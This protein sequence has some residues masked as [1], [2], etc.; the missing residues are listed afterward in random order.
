MKSRYL[1]MLA[2]TA[3]TP[4]DSGDWI[5]EIKW[6]G[7]R[8]IAYVGDS[9][10][11]K[12]RNDRELSG[13]FPELN[14]L[15]SLAPG[16]VLD[17]EIIAMTGGKPDIQALLPRLQVKGGGSRSPGEAPVT[18]IIFDILEK[19][20]K[21]LT[22]LPLSERRKILVQTVKES[23]NVV[24][25]RPIDSLGKEYY[26]AAVARGLEG[27]MAKRRDSLYEPGV[28]SAQWL[29][30]RA[31]K[32][33]DCIIVGYTRGRG[34]RNSIFGSLLLG[35][36]EDRPVDNQ[37]G[38]G[39]ATTIPVYI[40]KVGTGFSTRDQEMLIGTFAPLKSEIPTATGTKTD[41]RITWLKPELVCEV[42]YQEVTRNKKLR[43][44]RFVRLREDKKARDC[45]MDQLE[46]RTNHILWETPQVPS[47]QKGEKDHEPINPPG[48]GGTE[49]E[50][51]LAKY[52]KKRD[53]S[54][55]VEPSGNKDKGH[56]GNEFV[57]H[58]HHARHLHYDLRL[59]RD[60]VLKSWAVPKGIPE[61]PGEKHLAVAV[62]DHPLDYKDFEGTIP[63]GEYGA[64]TVSIWD[65]G[66]YSTLAWADD[67]IE[68]AFHGRRLNGRYVLI[69][70]KRA[71]KSEWLVF[72]A[73]T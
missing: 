18:Y 71:G 58:E 28:R 72:K 26:R 6:D 5:F 47:D 20:G 16:T 17:G 53:F 40:G 19:D 25:S 63:A 22:G 14:A 55:T 73:G 48:N 4:F 43:I 64:G 50:L 56:E 68:V 54:M 33:C 67:K 35:L 8:A 29:K 52:Q 59:E 23:P 45:T 37:E 15:L 1:P 32:S 13:Q 12:S 42:A 21:P 38:Q 62:E 11:L 61:L 65:R 57:V 10:S 49:P 31:V 46:F 3:D 24:I 30:V 66:W 51:P 34:N 27:I 60:G 41:R 36:Y 7:V 70:F 39:S 9:L 2:K 44:P 69:R